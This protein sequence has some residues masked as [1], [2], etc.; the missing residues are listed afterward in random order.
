MTSGPLLTDPTELPACNDA[1]TDVAELVRFESLVIDLAACFL[2]LEPDQVDQAIGDCLRHI[3]VTLG[4]DRSTLFQRSGDDLVVTHSW[5]VPGQDP[6]PEVWGRADLPWSSAEVMAGGSIVFSSLDDLP[7]EAAV[8]RSVFA[9]FGPRSNASMPLTAG[10]QVIG[11]L[12]FGTMRAERTWSPAVLSRLRSVAH[13]VAG[14]LARRDMDHQLRA[15]L[16]TNEELRARLE[17]ENKYLCEQARSLVGSPRLVGQG[18]AM[19]RVLS[20][21]ERV[22]PTDA[23]VLIT[24]ETGVGKELVAEEIHARSSRAG[25]TLVKVNCA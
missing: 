23:P 15:A 25:R 22:A 5:A 17:R 18:R 1:P 20:I 16:V 7:P 14:V 8:D 6:F 21:V 9:R 19:Q 2:H 24:G 4:L 12:A 11:A 10:G 13:M 3:V